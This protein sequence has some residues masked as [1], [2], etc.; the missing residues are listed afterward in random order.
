MPPGEPGCHC[1]VWV[2]CCLM[3]LTCYPLQCCLLHV[4]GYGLVSYSAGSHCLLVRCYGLVYL[5][6]VPVFQTLAWILPLRCWWLPS[7]E[8]CLA[9][10]A[11]GPGLT[12]GLPG[13]KFGLPGWQACR[14]AASVLLLPM[15]TKCRCC[16]CSLRTSELFAF[17][18][19]SEQLSISVG[20]VSLAR[21][22]GACRWLAWDVLCRFGGILVGC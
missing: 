5:P 1:V 19:C 4:V 20:A 13:L 11:A 16:R 15:V 9:P 14:R 18:C 6:G 8:G 17:S 22:A 12:F 10:P 3:R 7:V 2:V 21:I